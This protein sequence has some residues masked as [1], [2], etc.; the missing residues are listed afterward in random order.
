MRRRLLLVSTSTTRG[1]AEKILYALATN[2]N[3]EK[4]EIA[5]FVSLKSLGVYGELLQKE[6]VLVESLQIDRTGFFS[7]AAHLQRIIKEKRPDVVLA[8]MYQAAQLCRLVKLISSISFKLISSHRVNPR[9]RSLSTLLADRILKAQDDLT[10]A[11]CAASASF[12]VDRQGYSAN[13]VQVIHNGIDARHSAGEKFALRRELDIPVDS[14]LIGTAG[15]L[16][17][18]KNH[19]ALIDAI[20]I[21]RDRNNFRCVIFGEGPERKALESQIEKLGLKSRVLLAGEK[22]NA[23]SFFPAMDV[24]VLPSLWEGF[25]S[26]ILEAM[27]AKIPVIASKVD[28]IPEIIKDGRN[29]FLVPAGNAEA[30]AGKIAELSEFPEDFGHTLLE[31][32]HETVVKRFPLSK[33]IAAYE[34]ILLET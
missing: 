20:E 1:G 18:Q 4:F 30:L 12:L 3:R 14:F 8:F 33:M 5:G 24:F 32:A 34:K 27:A 9:A 2:L 10:V 26:V 29:G 22:E 15:R 23:A 16:H 7:V 31:N 28:G 17:K 6:N 25:P 19:A 21:L 13:K 11:E